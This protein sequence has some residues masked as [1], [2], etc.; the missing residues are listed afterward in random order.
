M[1]RV[2]C[3]KCRSKPFLIKCGPHF[4]SL[5][6]TFFKVSAKSFPHHVT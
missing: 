4:F 6:K 3:T 2:A 5:D 1:K